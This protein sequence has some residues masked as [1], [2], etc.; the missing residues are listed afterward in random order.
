MLLLL[1]VAVFVATNPVLSPQFHLWLL[2]LCALTLGVEAR[3]RI[4][5]AAG[6]AVVFILI[7]A[8]IVPSF[9]PTRAFATGLDL[10]RTLCLVLRN[11]L[12]LYGT[13]RLWMAVAGGPA[14]EVLAREVPARAG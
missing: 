12:L 13:V 1:P 3:G 8:L 10:G 7:S 9:Y 6:R 5:P 2:P 11:G 4:P 14:R